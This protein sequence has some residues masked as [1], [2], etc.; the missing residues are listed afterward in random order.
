M[1][2]ASVL[3][4][5]DRAADRCRTFLPDAAA[6][7]AY[8][9]DGWTLLKGV[10]R[11]EAVAP[12]REEVLAV[13]RTRNLPDS[14][15]AQAQEYLAGGH[16]DGW[17]N[18]AR[19]RGIAGALLG[20]PARVY[21]EFTAV[22]GP[23]QGAFG[24]HQDNNYT[25]HRGASLNCWLALVPMC[26]ANGALRVVTGSHADG[27]VAG[28]PSTLNSGHREVAATPTSWVDVMM[29]PGDLCI[30]DRNTVHGSGANATDAPRVAY[31]VQFH[32]EDTE[33]FFDGRWELLTTRPRFRT[34]P[35]EHLSAEAQRTE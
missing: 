21:M 24:F 35:S 5:T 23:Q 7:A 14:Y 32:R 17:I 26:A 33:A 29:D 12:M 30:F 19:L 6:I 22:K 8:R 20:G 34:A 9:R 1:S 25:P 31:A 3:S 10:L 2:T 16:L 28:R 27:T 11:P 13:L 4:A 15:L 18:G